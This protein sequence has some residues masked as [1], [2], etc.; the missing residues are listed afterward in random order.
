MIVRLVQIVNTEL[1]RGPSDYCSSKRI[2]DLGH[3][4]VFNLNSS[5]PYQP[6]FQWEGGFGKFNLQV[7]RLGVEFE[8]HI[9]LVLVGDLKLEEVATV[10]TRSYKQLFLLVEVALV[11]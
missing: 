8:R 9:R 2:T 4:C 5:Q 1:V 7:L 10:N 6:I 3:F 11:D